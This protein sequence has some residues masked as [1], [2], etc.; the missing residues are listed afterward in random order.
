VI[1]VHKIRGIEIKRP[2]AAVAG[3]LLM[4]VF[5]IVT[6]NEAFDAINFDVIFLLLGMMAL[7]AGLEFTGV[8]GII[9][10]FLLD[11]SPTRMRL[12]ANIMVLSAFMSAIALNDATVLMFTPIVIKCSEKLRTNPIPY[13]VGMMMAANIGSI[14]TAVGNPQNA[15][16][17]AWA[18][19]DFLTYLMYSVPISLVC[20]PVAFGI[21]WSFYRKR[22]SEVCDDS[23]DKSTEEVFDPDRPRLKIMVAIT[24]LMFVGFSLSSVFHYKLYQVALVAGLASLIVVLSKD[25]S[26][27]KWFAMRINWGILAFFIGLFVLIAGAV[28][29]G[30]VAD[31][32]AL[33][34]GFGAGQTPDIV[35]LSVFTAILSNL[36]SNV[37]AVMLIS[38][39]MDVP[40]LALSIA[41]A[42]SSTLAGNATLIG[43]AANVIVAERS[44][45]FGVKLDFFRFMTVG[46]I[47]TVATIAVM[48]LAVYFMMLI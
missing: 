1:A 40:T 22:L 6:F 36:V 38:N 28:N 18:G 37:P 32:S 7:V 8:F 31:I 34:P 46:V 20:L 48:L 4:L 23:H 3:G 26:E 14:A 39:M 30:L 42:A 44:E 16:V 17:V 35:G 21:I 25:P 47:V 15:Y 45:D 13:L 33:F 10:D 19:I 2:Y 5:G 11:H 9:S 29:T 24:L 12:L 41:L 27:A 43:S